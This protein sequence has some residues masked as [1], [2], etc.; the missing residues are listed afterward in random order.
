MRPGSSTSRTPGTVGSYAPSGRP[1]SVQGGINSFPTNHGRYSSKYLPYALLDFEK[2]QVFVNAVSG[3]PENPLWAGEGTAYKFD[4]SRATD[5]SVQIF[6]RNPNASPGSGRSED[7][8]LG[9]CRV[10]PRFEDRRALAEESKASRKDKE[11]NALQSQQDRS[12]GQWGEEWVSVQSGTGQIKI[13][14]EYAENQAK[15]LTIDDF[16]LL[17]VVGKGSFGKVMQVM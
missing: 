5:L 13:G 10:K 7:I 15:G 11:K 3:T 1:Q 16:E 17:K 8:Y 14:V 9:G 2:V 4:V 6:L 12:Q